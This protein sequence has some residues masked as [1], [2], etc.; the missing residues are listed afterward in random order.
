MALLESH[1]K[2]IPNDENE[3]SF[4]G[5]FTNFLPEE[6]LEFVFEKPYEIIQKIKFSKMER[7]SDVSSR[8][9]N[10]NSGITPQR[11]IQWPQKKNKRNPLMEIPSNWARKSWLHYFERNEVLNIHHADDHVYPTKK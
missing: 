8:E 7:K 5:E 10:S 1:P 4:W 3:K 9:M 2:L 11:A 6:E